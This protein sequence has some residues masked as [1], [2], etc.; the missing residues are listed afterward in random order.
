MTKFY[1]QINK[2]TEQINYQLGPMFGDVLECL[3]M[4]QNKMFA[5]Q[6]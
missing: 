2:L 4:F 5:K 1:K 3:A 6:K